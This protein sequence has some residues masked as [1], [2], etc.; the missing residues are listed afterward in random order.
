MDDVFEKVSNVLADVLGVN[1]D[2]ITMD[3]NLIDDL[4]AES[5]DF[6]DIAFSLE[7]EFKIKINP[8][9]IFPSF[10]SEISP[11]DSDGKL[12]KF[13]MDKFKNDYPHISNE[14][15]TEFEKTKNNTVFFFVKNIVNFLKLKVS[16]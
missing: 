14:L 9:D 5:I 16:Q 6:V 3:A 4:A 1:Q 10:L 15:I 2:E 11:F 13:A 8:E 7:Q 12:T